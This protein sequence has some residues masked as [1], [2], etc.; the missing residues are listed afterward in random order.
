MERRNQLSRWE[1]ELQTITE[2]LRAKRLTVGF[3]ESCTGGLLSAS[4]AA[5]PGVSDVYMGSIVSYAY[6][7]KTDLLGVSWETL[8]SL[9][10]VSEEVA[11]QMARGACERLKANYSIAITGI[12]GPTGGTPEKPVGTVWFAVKGPGFEI[13]QKKVFSGNRVSVQE[14][15]VDFALKLL[16]SKM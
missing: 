3:A 10:A 16:I 4:L 6:S 15:S 14:Q 7:A 8:N 12:A 2:S 13:A 9:G 5:L 1:N 11:L